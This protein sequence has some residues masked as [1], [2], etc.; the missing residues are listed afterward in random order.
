MVQAG[1]STNEAA[2]VEAAGPGHDHIHEHGHEEHDEHARLRDALRERLVEIRTMSVELKTYT[3]LAGLALLTLA[4]LS[5]LRNDLLG[6]LVTSPTFS[7]EADKSAS[8]SQIV[9]IVCVVI[10]CLG[11]A[12][13]VTAAAR[14]GW[15]TRVATAAALG[16][17]FG[18]ERTAVSQINLSTTIAAAGLC[19]V[20]VLI[21][22]LTWFGESGVRRGEDRPVAVSTTWRVIRTLVFPVSFAVFLALYGLIWHE[23]NVNDFSDNFPASTADQLDNVEWLLIPILTL[24]GADFGDWGNFAAGRA[25]ARVR[26]WVGRAAFTA[27]AVVVAGAIV[28]DGMRIAY[29]DDGGGLLAELVL[30]AI[31][32][33]V[34]TYLL[35]ACKPRD[36]WPAHAPFLALVTCVVIDT[37]SSYVISTRVN[38]DP[39]GTRADGW[40]ALVWLALATVA[41]V[42]LTVARRRLPDWLMVGAIFAVLIGVVYT[43]TDLFSVADIVHPFGLTYDNSP[44]VGYEGLKAVAGLVTLG[45]IVAAAVSRRL[46]AWAEPIAML[47]R[48]TISMQVLAWIDSLYGGAVRQSGTAKV[49]GQLALAAAVVL[50]LALSWEFAASGES[51]TN[52]HARRFPRDSR[53]ML[54]LGYVVVTATTSVFFSNIGE[55]DDGKWRVLESQ[56]EAEGYVRDGLLFLGGP[57]VITIFIVSVNRWRQQRGPTPSAAASVGPVPVAQP[58]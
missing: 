30:G 22:V 9:F 21:L 42:A 36:S 2:V 57:L 19:G 34:A 53:V 14:A 45:A 11:W 39:S 17:A 40:D 44:W 51:I 6:T 54:F 37:V 33:A 23:S 4:V 20:V 18:T 47:L 32:A 31:V 7:D 25:I 41:L 52:G 35:F 43:A 27:I 1:E 8:M 12:L 3:A 38:N 5:L 56:F 26:G 48:L 29:S 15:L 24:A 50:V 16:L 46:T 49:T 58:R 13:V 28:A 55:M 10:V